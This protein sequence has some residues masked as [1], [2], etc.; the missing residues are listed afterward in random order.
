MN[1]QFSLCHTNLD[2]CF[3]IEISIYRF[4][5]FL[6]WIMRMILARAMLLH[7]SGF[8]K[9]ALHS[10]SL[11]LALLLQRGE[12]LHYP[13]AIY[14]IRQ[15]VLCDCA[16]LGTRVRTGFNGLW[17]ISSTIFSRWILILA[18]PLSET[19]SIKCRINQC[20]RED[21]F[22]G[23]WGLWTNISKRK[24]TR[25]GEMVLGEMTIDRWF[26]WFWKWMLQNNWH[27]YAKFAICSSARLVVLDFQW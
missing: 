13:C 20:W 5:H 12:S 19:E 21:C 9:G 23:Y 4:I 10:L 18:G 15:Q 7:C 27:H 11:I 2:L 22:A 24:R 14:F 17:Y 1:K 16:T 3:V 26:R 25:L 6:P 8:D